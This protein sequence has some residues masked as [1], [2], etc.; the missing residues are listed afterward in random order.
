L[1]VTGRGTKGKSA[2]GPR[3]RRT[4]T[5]GTK[6][7]KSQYKRVGSHKRRKNPR[8]RKEPY[9]S[10]NMKG[11]APGQKTAHR[12]TERTCRRCQKKG[13]ETTIGNVSG[14]KTGACRDHVR[15]KGIGSQ[16]SKGHIVV[17][18]KEPKDAGVAIRVIKTG[19]WKRL[20]RPIK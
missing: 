14:K 9:P 1:R 3:N 10:K 12:N 13:T 6:G 5:F 19:K 7:G 15:K 17:F 2:R 4:A 16:K 8:E 11:P 20:S 18:I